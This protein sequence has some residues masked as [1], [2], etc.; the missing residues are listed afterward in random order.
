MTRVFH[1][2]STP[3]ILYVLL[4]DARHAEFTREINFKTGGIISTIRKVSRANKSRVEGP[5]VRNNRRGYY[6]QCC[7]ARGPRLFPRHPVRS[8]Q[9]RAGQR[10][11]LP[12]R[13]GNRRAENGFADSNLMRFHRQLTDPYSRLTWINGATITNDPQCTPAS[14]LLSVRRIHLAPLRTDHL[15]SLMSFCR[16]LH[17]QRISKSRCWKF[18]M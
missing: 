15:S 10:C 13:G 16:C 4:S 8:V 2:V 17:R 6:L 18:A 14:S 11:G 9:F 1:D 3:I 12:R 7:V 5:I